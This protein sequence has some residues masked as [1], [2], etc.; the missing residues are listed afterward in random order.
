MTAPTLHLARTHQDLEHVNTLD[1][2]L[3]VR[4][5]FLFEGIEFN[6]DQLK[7]ALR[8]PEALID[9]KSSFKVMQSK[10]PLAIS[11]L[12]DS[13][14]EFDSHEQG[15]R[16]K[17]HR[18]LKRSELKTA[19][20]TEDAHV[21]Y[22]G[23]A[24][25][26]RGPCFGRGTKDTKSEDWEDGTS[27]DTGIFRM[28]FP[29]LAI[30][31]TD[32]LHHG[33]TANLVP[34]SV[35]IAAADC[36]PDLKPHVS[37]LQAKT[38]AQ[39]HPELPAQVKDTDPTKKFWTYEASD[40]GTKR[41]HLVLFADFQN[42][43]KSPLDLGGTDMKARVFGHFGC[44]TLKHNRDVVVKLK[45]YEQKDDKRFS[46]FTTNLSFGPELVLYFYHLFT[47]PVGTRGGAWEPS[48][49][50]AIAKTNT[51]LAASGL[52]YRLKA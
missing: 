49:E 36:D 8:V 44:S 13:E 25:F 22:S 24:R 43:P 2:R 26:G 33:Y 45:G 47:C 17:V 10:K 34:S 18:K 5:V 20:E 42:T 28:G 38:A 16:Y 19:L 1:L 29:F 21:I 27:T 3:E 39:I 9:P 50:H 46:I 41:P 35:K 15:V 31:I 48:I 30:P 4:H 32:V 51:D 14:F 7:P 23:H 52:N 40:E 12:S 6:N 11:A 37:S